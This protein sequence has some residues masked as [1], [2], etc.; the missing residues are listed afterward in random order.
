MATATRETTTTTVVA[1]VTLVMSAAEAGRVR[2]AVHTMNT[3]GDDGVRLD[4]ILDA[5]LAV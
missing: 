5:A 1:T 3:V 4:S 2:S